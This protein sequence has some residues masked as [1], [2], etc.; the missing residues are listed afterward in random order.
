[1]DSLNMFKCALLALGC[2]TVAGIVQTIFYKHPVSQLFAVALDGGRCWR[3]R[4]LF[5]DNKTWKGVVVLIPM[6]TLCFGAAGALAH[7][8]PAFGQGLW[9]L[10]PQR[11]L[12]LGFVA[13]LGYVLGELPNSMLKR[14][15]DIEPGHTATHPIG[16][17]LQV[18]WDQFDSLLMGLLFIALMVPTNWIFHLT[19]VVIGATVHWLFN[20]LFVLLGLKKEAR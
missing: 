17:R 3:G 19:C 14:Q 11:W 5:G 6:T 15:L 2:F 18:I 20:V 4:R 8:W 7:L 16:K 1:M 9:A 10:T 13:A 12:I